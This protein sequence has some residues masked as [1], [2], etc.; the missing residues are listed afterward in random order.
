MRRRDFLAGCGAAGLVA[1]L[2][3]CGR[4][5]PLPPGEMDGG[6]WETGHR[7]REGGF[8]PP[9]ETIDVPVLVVG[10]GVGGLS[11][12]WR[13]CRE[14]GALAALGGLAVLELEARAGGNARWGENAISRYPLGAHYLPLPNPEARAVR[15]LLADLGVLRG[16]VDAPRPEYDE[17]Y[18]CHAP[19]ERLYRQGVWQEGLLPR[20]D[21]GKEEIAQQERFFA[22]MAAFRDA[23]DAS[24]RRAFALPLAY[25]GDAPEW[26]A[27]DGQTM[28]DW[29]LAEGFDAPSLHWYVDYACRDDYGTRHD[30]VSA[31]AGVHYFASRAN[32]GT[33]SDDVVL[34][35]PEGNGWLV[36]GLR[37]RIAQAPGGEAVRLLT[38]Q[39]AY[40]LRQDE[41]GCEVHVWDAA[42]GVGQ[43]WRARQVVWAAPLFLLPRVASGLPDDLARSIADISY[44]PWLVANLSLK[45]PPARGKGMEL[46]WDNVLQDSDGLG[47]VVATHQRIRVAPGPTVITYYRALAEF[48]PSVAR[49]MLLDRPREAWA[50]EALADLSRAHG[51]LRELVTRLDVFRHG[52]AMARPTPG[53]REATRR[54]RLAAGWGRVRFA[55][56][57]VS[58]LSLFE[59]AN[60]HGVRAAE[61][62]LAAHGLLRRRLV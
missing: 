25:S 43:R 11:A 14:D 23:R 44:A 15:A 48:D 42:R 40:A 56:A 57:D 55:H 35:A 53:F 19:H 49:Q 28:R 34:T 1:A 52:H 36:D 6:A 58:G 32:W 27:L 7:L 38:K 9:V 37:K 62:I 22:R 24:G 33:D 51:D 45:A 10:A 30:K 12:A 2:P 26:A 8:P 46:A 13:L 4:T 31:W 59:E 20:L 29:M 60:Y 21:V 5:P 50:E 17:R 47:Y 61:D 3:G 54:R 41:H 16:D 18:L 39:F